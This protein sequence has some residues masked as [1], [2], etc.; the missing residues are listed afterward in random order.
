METAW[1]RQ[2]EPKNQPPLRGIFETFRWHDGPPLLWK[3]QHAPRWQRGQGELQLRGPQLLDLTDEIAQILPP[4]AQLRARLRLYATGELELSWRELTDDELQPKPWNLL[5]I[6]EVQVRS[7]ERQWCKLLEPDATLHWRQKA[8]QLG[9][10]EAL[11]LGPNQRWAETPTAN[12]L[13]GLDDGRMAMPHFDAGALVGTTEY[14]FWR[15]LSIAHEHLDAT[16]LPRIR[17]AALLNAIFLLRPVRSIDGQPLASPPP[18]L[19]PWV[20]DLRR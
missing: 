1:L 20:D 4:R 2:T 11:L 5:T 7:H 18:H 6:G 16:W 9:A 12:L 15:N 10:D 8:Q 13:V 14:F 3:W 19:Q 17:W